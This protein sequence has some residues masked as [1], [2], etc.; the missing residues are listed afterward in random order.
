MFNNSIFMRHTSFMTSEFKNQRQKI[1][2]VQYKFMVPHALGC[3]IYAL[4][5]KEGNLCC[6]SKRQ[7]HVLHY[8]K[9]MSRD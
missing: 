4:E 7:D 1:R 2:F 6:S 8:H 9:L 3:I 5:R